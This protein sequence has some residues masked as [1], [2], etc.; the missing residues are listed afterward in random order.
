M[1]NDQDV[2]SVQ[3]FNSTRKKKK[4]ITNLIFV[5]IFIVNLKRMGWQLLRFVQFSWKEMENQT[6]SWISTSLFW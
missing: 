4:V 3:S 2:S 6:S 5:H 1:K